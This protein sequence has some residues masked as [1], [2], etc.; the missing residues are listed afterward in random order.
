MPAGVR[1][2]NFVGK[3]GRSGRKSAL[4]EGHKYEAIKRAW[5]KVYAEL[6]SKDVT[7]VALPLA[8]RDMT[9]K[10]DITTQGEKIDAIQY[11]IPNG[12]NNLETH[13]ETAPGLPSS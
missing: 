4:V 7:A 10:S 13:S 2:P 11:I 12:N 9:L 6:E 5:A 8:L 1:P 3:K